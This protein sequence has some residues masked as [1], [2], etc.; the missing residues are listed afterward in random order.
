MSTDVD[1]HQTLHLCPVEIWDE[2]KNEESYLPEAYD[3]DGFIHCTDTDEQ[4]VLVGNR[5]YTADPR[6]FIVL[7]IDLGANNERWIYEDEGRIFPHIYGPIH[8]SSV[9]AIRPVLRAPDGT[10]TGFGSALSTR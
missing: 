5:Y 2:Q 4:L 10:F 3:D 9:V 7:T 6:V 8:P 1:S